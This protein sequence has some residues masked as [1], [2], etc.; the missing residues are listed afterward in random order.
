MTTKRNAYHPPVAANWWQKSAFYRFY[1]LREAT[2]IP[3]L[4]FSLELI[5]GL[6][7]LK[8]GAE[9]WASFVAFL[10]HSVV[11]LLNV[12][13]LAASLLHSK[14][15]FELAPKASV[16]VIGDKKLSPAPVIKGL[17]VVM[18]LVSLALLAAFFL[19]QR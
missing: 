1:M 2:A 11:L 8:N 19:L 16:I 17:W 10:Q 3:A 18:I 12:L 7:A 4:W 9:S 13:A 5:F 6:F 15:W 14:T